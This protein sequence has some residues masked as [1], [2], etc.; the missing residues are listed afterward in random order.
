MSD[1][2]PVRFTCTLSLDEGQVGHLPVPFDPRERFGRAR[3]PVIVTV[4]GHRYRST[5]SIMAGETFVPFRRSARE[6]AGVAPGDPGAVTLRLDRA[7]RAV[8]VAAGLAGGRDLAGA[9][10]AWDALSFS[11]QREWAEAIEGAKKPETRAKRI[12][13]AVAKVAG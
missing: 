7:P 13:A 2:D 9:G 8:A 5:V 10:G 3:P 6:A 11:H 1:V 4:A 12:A